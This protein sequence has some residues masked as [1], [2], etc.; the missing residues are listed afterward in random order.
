MNRIFGEKS[1]KIVFNGITLLKFLMLFKPE[2][3]IG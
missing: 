1:T 3:V 2:M